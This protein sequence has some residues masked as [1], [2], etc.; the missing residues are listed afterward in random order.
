M[1][2]ANLLVTLHVLGADVQKADGR[3]RDPMGGAVEGFAED[4]ELILLKLMAP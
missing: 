1:G 4:G 2:L 3:P